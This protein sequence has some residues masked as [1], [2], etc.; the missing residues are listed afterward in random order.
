MPINFLAK[1][2]R[3]LLVY[4]LILAITCCNL[5]MADSENKSGWA[6]IAAYGLAF[7][8]DGTVWAWGNNQSGQLGN[9][10]GGSNA[11]TSLIP[12]Q[13]KGLS[14]VIAVAKGQGFSLA[15]KKDGTVWAWGNNSSGEIGDGTQSVFDEK[16][17]ATLKNEDRY[18]PVQ[19]RGL[20]D[21]TAIAANW[22]TS[23]AVKKD[24]TL[25]S[26]GGIYY[27]NRDGSYS[28]N[29]TPKQLEGFSDIVS[30]SLGWGNM[31]ALNKDGTV[32]T[33]S[34][35]RAVHIKGTSDIKEIAAGGQYSYGLKKDGTVWFWG[36]G[37][38]G[39]VAGKNTA[40]RSQPQLLKGIHDVVSVKASA[41]G[42][43]LLKRDGTVWASGVNDGG[44]LGIGSYEDS[45]VPVQVKGLT[46]IKE[47]NASGIDFKSMAFKE[48]HTLWSWG[49]NYVG[50]GTEWY[51]TIPVWIKSYD[52]EVL[53]EDRIR[54]KLDGTE[55]AFDQPP[56]LINDD[57][58]VPLRKIF[59]ALDADVTWDNI[60]STVTAIKGQ[61]VI[62]L[63]VG[64][65]EAKVDG[66][67]Q[68][69]DS[70]PILIGD[71]MFVPIRFIAESFGATVS[72]EEASK[73]ILIKSKLK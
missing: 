23:Y 71:N 33:G 1:F 69:L 68:M 63:T 10:E 5:V 64:S 53:L 52:S 48:D 18:L 8:Q 19:V 50:D 65:N 2:T 4:S 24:G 66:V 56:I 62:N 70:K 32:W 36:S 26:W 12:T 40:D 9:G 41:G 14:D 61:M 21:I 51:R 35:G 43:L 60:A 22:N 29:T 17:H 30:V 54:V 42:P 59:E 25:W 55:L 34:S 37:G 72:W 31:I 11:A 28:N 13:V 57:T 67:S 45:E 58:M 15:L 38:Q 49:S 27:R 3:I 16:T 73:T 20:S 44:Q 47:I 39:V 7:K 6:G 46:R